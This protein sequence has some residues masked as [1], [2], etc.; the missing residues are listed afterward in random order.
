[1]TRDRLGFRRQTETAMEPAFAELKSIR[2]GK[3]KTKTGI[4]GGWGEYQVLC[5]ANGGPYSFL[6]FPSYIRSHLTC[7]FGFL[8]LLFYL[9][10]ASRG[11]MITAR[12]PFFL[13]SLSFRLIRFHAVFFLFSAWQI[14]K[15]LWCFLRLFFN[16]NWQQVENLTSV[17]DT[18]FAALFSLRCEKCK[19]NFKKIRSTHFV[20]PPSIN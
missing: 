18:Q 5:S 12:C 1:M 6:L 2:P 4:M 13:I 10:H 9:L 3:K 17:K 16:L 19:K 14:M 8:S 11:I 15:D 20:P 7:A